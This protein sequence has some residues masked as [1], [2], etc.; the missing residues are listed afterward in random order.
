MLEQNDLISIIIP[1]FN[2]ERY[3]DRCIKSVVEQTY[4]KIEVIII[5]DGSVD[6]SGHKSDEWAE[7]DNRVRVIHKSN[8]GVSDTR[9]IGIESAKG[10]YISFID[11]DDFVEKEYISTLYEKILEQ[12]TD[13]VACNFKAEYEDGIKKREFLMI[14]DE[15]VISDYCRLFEDISNMESYAVMVWG[16]LYRSE[17]IK[18]IRFKQQ[19]YAEDFR[20]L[21]EI[22]LKN[23]KVSLTTY[24]GYHY[25][26]NSGGV[27]NDL[28]RR[29]QR[30]IEELS[31]CWDT[32]LKFKKVDTN[33]VYDK[34]EQL[35][36]MKLKRV[37]GRTI[38]EA[39][40]LSKDECSLIKE[41]TGSFSL[42]E[43]KGKGYRYLIPL[44]RFV[45][46][47]SKLKKKKNK[48]GLVTIY[49]LGN[50][51][52]RLQNYATVQYLTNMG[53]DVETL[54]IY[55]KGIKRNLKQA[56]RLLIKKKKTFP[57]WNVW[58][59]SKDFVEKLTPLQKQRYKLFKDFSYKYTKVKKI[60]YWDEAHWLLENKYDYFVTG[61]DQV[62]NPAIGQ[63]ASW[64]FLSF[65]KK[66]KNTSWSASFGISEIPE[67][68]KMKLTKYLLNI[69]HISVREDTAVDIVK[70]LSGKE[71]ELLIDP[72]M[73]ISSSEWRNLSEAPK[74][75]LA[76]KYILSFFLG[77]QDEERREQIR[78]IADEK[79]CVVYNLLDDDCD[80]LY[81]TGP[82]QFIHL[83]DHAALVCTDSFHACVFSVLLDRAFCVFD[84]LGSGANMN[85][86]ISNLLDKFELTTGMCEDGRIDR[87]VFHHNYDRAYDILKDE[88]RKAR[89]FLLNALK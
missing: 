10:K 89:E 84:R 76:E 48:I 7:K 13:I 47:F 4:K 5:D 20:F 32:W 46:L 81:E 63:A 57:H 86:R 31:T 55:Q 73:M 22:F 78:E 8:S 69:S 16:K 43:N 67:K 75:E 83:I 61:S 85:S 71:A 28:T 70:N 18:G 1:V 66:E 40:P 79:R 27:T 24:G 9:N 80:I 64:E 51:G 2:A 52:N 29:R 36:L 23:P 6:S 77:G 87:N 45:F 82:A 19:A 37:I 14:T 58:Q 33:L 39:N 53:Y 44:S 25:L 65:S 42:F 38:K 60:S 56:V 50:Y 72:T 62:W 68:Y 34:L 41:V 26:I 3:L 17:I 88:Q 12:K 74:T 30:A 21:I 49:D 15:E 59:E 54:I 35:I 11:S